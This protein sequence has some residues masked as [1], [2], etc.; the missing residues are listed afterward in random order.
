MKIVLPSPSQYCSP[1]RC[2]S[3]VSPLAFCN[4]QLCNDWSDLS[5]G[6]WVLI[7][8]SFTA[9]IFAFQPWRGYTFCFASGV[10]LNHKGFTNANFGKSGVQ[11]AVVGWR[12]KNIPSKE[13]THGSTMGSTAA[14]PV[15]GDGFA[16]VLPGHAFFFGCPLF[17][18]QLIGVACLLR[19]LFTFVLFS[20]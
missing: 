4:L 9:Q 1:S 19:R 8:L 2:P 7:P 15:G 11:H 5:Y 13:G 12:R 16:V 10:K 14:P 17:C 20:F 6:G 18:C 3:P